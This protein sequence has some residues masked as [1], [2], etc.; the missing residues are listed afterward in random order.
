MRFFRQ[1]LLPAALLFVLSA[2]YADAAIVNWTYPASSDWSGAANW[3]GPVPTANDDAYISNGGTAAIAQTAACEW[4]FVDRGSGITFE[5]GGVGTLSADVED[6][7]LSGT[8]TITQT[9]G[10]NSISYN[11]RLG[12]D[13]GSKG[14]YLLGGTGT[15]ST[16]LEFVGDGRNGAG[17][18]QQS[19]GNHSIADSL[20]LGN[21]GTGTFTLTG[22]TQT[23][24]NALV[25]ATSPSSR[26]T[27]N[28]EG[29]TL[30]LKSISKG[31]GTAAFNFGGGTLKLDGPLSSNLPMTLTGTGGNAN[32]DSNSFAAALS[33]LLSGAGGL[34]KLG[35]GVLTLSAMN[36][37]RG[38]TVVEAGTLS[39]EGGIDAAGTSL[40]DVQAGLAVIKTVNVNKP[41]L[42][43]HTA[44][45]AK[46][47]FSSGSHVVGSIAGTGITQVDST[48]T[49]TAASIVQN[50]LII[51]SF[52][53]AGEAAIT[54]DNPAV[55]VPEPG[56]IVIFLTGSFLAFA[57]FLRRK[58]TS[59]GQ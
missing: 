19:G 18:F 20:Y 46:V 22:G 10:S 50:T 13:A 3:D 56:S 40:L 15:L 49:L 45:A 51:G 32:L 11:L 47:R 30:R 33:G 6:V 26:G 14:T 36:S 43:I 27:Y 37:Y 34:N 17:T 31:S 21:A 9:A 54:G 24:S 7:G 28:L 39:I 53:S 55:C 35:A 1:A 58:R 52:P 41:N 57:A 59:A 38:D 25:L 48:A 42:D 2:M 23:I 5:N 16:N 12:V 4:L 8:G 29:G 44:D